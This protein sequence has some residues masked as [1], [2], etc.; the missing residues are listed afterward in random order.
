MFPTQVVKSQNDWTTD[1][2]DGGACVYANSKP[3]ALFI[4]YNVI[5]GSEI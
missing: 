4:T 3:V 1:F 5:L 2:I